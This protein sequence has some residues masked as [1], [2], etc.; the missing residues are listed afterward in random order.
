MEAAKDRGPLVPAEV[1]PRRPADHLERLAETFRLAPRAL[2]WMPPPLGGE[3][4]ERR[5]DLLDGEDL[6]HHPRRDRGGGHALV[7]RVA[8]EL[9]EGPAPVPLHRRDT[10][11][12]V[13]ARPR[14]HDA[15]GVLALVLREGGQERIHQQANALRV[16]SDE[17]QGAALDA[18]LAPGGMTYTW[19][20]SMRCPSVAIAT[21][22]FV[23][24]ARISGRLLS[25]SGER[26]C[27]TT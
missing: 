17:P 11:G 10:E 1:V 8:G 3:L 13:G 27:T 18:R 24:R 19:S 4:D 26:C 9:G 25:C 23:A 22:S 21:G 2:G 6:L 14:E 7:L 16:R 15:D 20:R 12:A 5:R